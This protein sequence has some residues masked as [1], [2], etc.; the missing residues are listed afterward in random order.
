MTAMINRAMTIG[1]EIAST[2]SLVTAGAG[3]VYQ[4]C[5]MTPSAITAPDITNANLWKK[6][7]NNNENLL[8]L[9]KET[10]RFVSQAFDAS[11]SGLFR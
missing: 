1:R 10:Y 6:I 9:L 2:I 4:S 3:V 5:P 11:P 7:K 8:N